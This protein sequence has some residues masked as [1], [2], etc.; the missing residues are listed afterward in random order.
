MNGDTILF[1]PP[2]VTVDCRRVAA[3]YISTLSLSLDHLI[4]LIEYNVFR[5]V[6]TNVR[7]TRLQRLLDTPCRYETATPWS[8]IPA[9]PSPYL[10]DSNGADEAPLP[11]SLRPTSLQSKTPH[12]P[13]VDILPCGQLRDNAIR[14]LQVGDFSLQELCADLLPG[15]GGHGD[16]RATPV[17]EPAGSSRSDTA[18][19]GMVVWTNPWE[20]SGWEVKPMFLKKWAW[21]LEGC[22][23]LMVAT[24][25]YRRLR[26]EDALLW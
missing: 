22:S 15:L 3:R 12:P 9:F 21:L 20:A 10:A 4:P 16:M 18:A 5:A 19:A 26:G 23:E 11:P 24:N 13:W 8:S 1:I 17:G 14:A 7:I 25:H 2:L 6:M